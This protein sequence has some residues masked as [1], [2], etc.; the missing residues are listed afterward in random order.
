MG[1]GIS[2][3]MQDPATPPS[4]SDST[5]TPNDATHNNTNSVTSQK[6]TK[7]GEDN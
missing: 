6:P 4:S 2:Y 3:L 1:N 5:N 7:S